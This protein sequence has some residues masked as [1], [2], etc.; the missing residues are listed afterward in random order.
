METILSLFLSEFA[1]DYKNEE[2]GVISSFRRGFVGQSSEGQNLDN[3]R[4]QTL[5]F[6]PTSTIFDAC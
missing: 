1:A 6:I 3:A 2:N 4:F 5:K